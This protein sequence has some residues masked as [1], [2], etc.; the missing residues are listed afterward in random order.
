MNKYIARLY[1]YYSSLTIFT[2]LQV[3]IPRP[4]FTLRIGECLFLEERCAGRK[5]EAQWRWLSQRYRFLILH[6]FQSSAFMASSLQGAAVLSRRG[7]RG[8]RRRLGG[9]AMMMPVR[10]VQQTITSRFQRGPTMRNGTVAGSTRVL[11]VIMLP[12]RLRR[13]FMVPVV[14]IIMMMVMMMVS[15]R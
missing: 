14:P 5:R 2:F 6:A 7:L 8:A 11:R 12:A 15:P 1:E 9:R 3:Q 13:Y 10:R 4:T